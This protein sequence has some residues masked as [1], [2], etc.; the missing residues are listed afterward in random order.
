MRVLL[1][2]RLFSGLATSVRDGRWEPAGVPAIYKLMEAF[3]RGPHDT[4]FVLVGKGPDPAVGGTKTMQGF[5]SPITVIAGEKSEPEWLGRVR[6]YATELRQAW[7][8]RRLMH[9]WPPDVVYCDRASAITGSLLARLTRVPV[10]L[11]L[12]GVSSSRPVV[13]GRGVYCQV[14]RWALRAPFAAVVCTQ[15]GSG[16]EMW[17]ARA[18]RPDVPRI[19]AFNGVDRGRPQAITHPVLAALPRDRMTVLFVG[20]LEPDK[21]CE[22][23][24]DAVLSLRQSHG[25]RLHAVIVGT[26]S[27]AESLKRK[28]ARA[29]GAAMATFI[30]RLSHAQVAEALRVADVYV[31]MN[32]AGNFSNANLEAMA[33]GLC[34][35]IPESQPDLG[36]DTATDQLIP[37]QAAIRLPRTEETEALAETLARLCD[38]PDERRARSDAA[39]AV[40][41]R[42]FPTWD[43]RIAAEIRFIEDVASGRVMRGGGQRSQET[44][45]SFHRRAP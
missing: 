6:P 24:L 39:A 43:E 40:A 31:S 7:T 30:E 29:D 36:I 22:A 21:G 32:R 44:F 25:G 10:V 1:V 41:R 13:Q 8:V 26:G 3:A 35:V 27:E 11:R 28:V 37:E 34:M 15:D 9:D 12:L 16:G 20:R 4:R 45:P 23:F 18:L 19:L 17:L 42:L 2:S 5:P 38:N 14:Q 33:A